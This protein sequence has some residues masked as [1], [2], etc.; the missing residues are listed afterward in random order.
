MK[1]YARCPGCR[2]NKLFLKKRVYKHKH[3]GVITSQD[4]VCRGC[5]KKLKKTLEIQ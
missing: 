2:K 3:A 5:Y 4:E 1:L